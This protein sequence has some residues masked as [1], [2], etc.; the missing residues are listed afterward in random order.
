MPTYKGKKYDYT[1]AGKKQMA[2]DK[3]KDAKKAKKKT[4]RQG[5]TRKKR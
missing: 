5:Y 3:A 1:A 4:N 2:A